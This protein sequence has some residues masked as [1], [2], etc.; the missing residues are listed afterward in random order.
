[1]D[2]ICLFT[3]STR[4]SRVLAVSFR[5]GLGVAVPLDWPNSRFIFTSSVYSDRKNTNK[6]VNLEEFLFLLGIYISKMI[7]TPK[8][9]GKG[10]AERRLCVK[11]RRQR[12]QSTPSSFVLRRIF[13]R[14]WLW[15]MS[16]DDKVL[17]H[18]YI[19]PMGRLA[20]KRSQ[21]AWPLSWKDWYL[22]RNTRSFDL[23]WLSSS[24]VTRGTS[25]SGREE[26]CQ[27]PD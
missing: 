23:T 9:R 21:T 3:V 15:K 24:R 6:Y 14:M 25:I 7:Q 19:P 1:M 2:A 22:N 10:E 27:M 5:V 18:W 20:R 17:L 26:D 13:L 16:H 8:R 11:W 12:K 4:E